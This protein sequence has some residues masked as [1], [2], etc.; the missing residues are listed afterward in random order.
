MKKILFIALL[1]L[2]G[3]SRSK[4]GVTSWGAYGKVLGSAMTFGFNNGSMTGRIGWSA[5]WVQDL[6]QNGVHTSI[7]GPGNQNYYL[8]Y[9]DFIPGMY[10]ESFPQIGGSQYG[11]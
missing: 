7:F 5:R 4:R 2:L 11:Y 10:L 9:S 1:A 6:F 8:N 3:T